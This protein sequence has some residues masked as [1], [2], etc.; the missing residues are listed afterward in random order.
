MQR[1]LETESSAE[2]ADSDSTAVGTQVRTMR[3]QHFR[4]SH[5]T[6]LGYRHGTEQLRITDTW[7]DSDMPTATNTQTVT[8]PGGITEGRRITE[9]PVGVRRI[10]GRSG[11]DYDSSTCDDG[12]E[13][14]STCESNNK[15]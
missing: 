2:E 6:T 1:E 9:T 13:H 15:S 11:H 4:R 10:Y 8:T 14:D 7:A 12:S 5:V 3:L